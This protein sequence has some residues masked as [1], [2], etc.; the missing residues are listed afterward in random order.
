[1]SREAY[2]A[3]ALRQLD[4]GRYYRRLDEDPTFHHAEQVRLLV[5]TMVENK[6]TPKE[7]GTYLAPSRVRTASYTISQ[8]FTNLETQ[9]DR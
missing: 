2:L 5:Q 1:M 3:E 4:D 9:E 7:T 8:R 6:C